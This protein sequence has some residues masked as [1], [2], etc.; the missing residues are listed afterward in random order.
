MKDV[1][2]TEFRPNFTDIVNPVIFCSERVAL[3]RHGK[4]V[5]VLMSNTD[6]ENLMKIVQE[7]D[8]MRELKEET[9]V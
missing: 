5:A 8:R 2:F 4:R 6:Y 1:P 3:T 7:F 9:D